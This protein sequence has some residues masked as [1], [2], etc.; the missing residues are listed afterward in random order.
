MRVVDKPLQRE[1]LHLPVV[2][3]M[4]SEHL[5]LPRPHLMGLYP[6]NQ[7]PRHIF[8]HPQATEHGL[9]PLHRPDR[10]EALPQVRQDLSPR[11]RRVGSSPLVAQLPRPHRLRDR[12]QS[13]QTLQDQADSSFASAATSISKTLSAS[14]RA[15]HRSV[16]S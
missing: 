9:D 16:I 1:N 14:S 5:Q 11:G 10:R 12:R 4:S 15:K 8:V 7:Q 2:L 6:N 3:A 13:L